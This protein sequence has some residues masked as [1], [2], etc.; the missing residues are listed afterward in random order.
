[1][2][3]PFS[4]FPLPAIYSSRTLQNPRYWQPVLFH[5]PFWW[6][7]YCTP[8]LEQRDPVPP[9]DPPMSTLCVN[10]LGKA[11]SI[12]FT[13]SCGLSADRLCQHSLWSNTVQLSRCFLVLYWI[14]CLWPPHW[15]SCPHPTAGS[16]GSR[17]QPPLKSLALASLCP[18]KCLF[19]CTGSLCSI[20]DSLCYRPGGPLT[21]KKVYFSVDTS[22]PGRQGLWGSGNVARSFC[23]FWRSVSCLLTLCIKLQY[24]LVVL[25]YGMYFQM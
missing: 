10:T 7:C 2:V 6:M 9:G 14:S 24:S 17:W 15:K 22:P 20:N 5:G 18:L 21:K 25:S 8:C 16:R 19:V 1:M 13:E 4:L 23:F 3:H 11:D 12:L